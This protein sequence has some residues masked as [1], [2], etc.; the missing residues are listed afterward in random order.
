MKNEIIQIIMGFIGS[1]GFGILFNVRGK[2]LAFASLGGLLSWG[3]F[4]L[5]SMF[6]KSEPLNYFLVALIISIYAEIMARILKTPTTTFI[7]TSLIPLIPGSSLY[8]TMAYA[9][10]SDVNNFFTKAVYTLQLASCLALG[11]IIAVTLTQIITRSKGKKT[12]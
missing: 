6:L 3:L 7:T 5:F 9:F 8:Y 4:V 12:A 11:I 2:R 10:N 1:L